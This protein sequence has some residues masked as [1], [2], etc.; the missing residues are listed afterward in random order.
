MPDLDVPLATAAAIDGGASSAPEPA[1]SS[2][3]F[4]YSEAFDKLC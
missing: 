2:S 3:Q 4:G 1:P